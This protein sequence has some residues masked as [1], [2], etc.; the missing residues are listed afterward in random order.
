M[1]LSQILVN[2]QGS[3]GH[4]IGQSFSNRMRVLKQVHFSALQPW[5]HTSPS[6]CILAFRQVDFWEPENRQAEEVQVPADESEYTQEAS[7]PKI[8][9]NLI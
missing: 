2:Q 9:K 5:E 1:N 3:S 8:A 6:P 4:S 7:V